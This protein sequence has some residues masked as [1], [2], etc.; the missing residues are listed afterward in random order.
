L[1]N[2]RRLVSLLVVVGA[3][4][5]DATPVRIA[6]ATDTVVINTTMLERLD[7]KVVN[8]N[9]VAIAGTRV[10][11]ASTAPDSILAIRGLNSIQCRNDGVARV[12]LSAGKLS[13]S[14]MVRCNII[15][16]IVAEQLVC[17]RLGNRPLSLSVAAYDRD[18][19][20]I[21]SPR[22]Y[23]ISDSSLVR[24][25]NGFMTPLRSGDGDIDYTNGRHRAVTL[26]RVLDTAAIADSG[27]L[28]R[29]L[30]VRDKMFESVCAALL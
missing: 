2:G 26:I 7:A 3:A 14:V 20:V 30:T 25:A 21:P 6:G 12:T 16:K 4:C 11:Y 8:R 15:E 1:T 18:G 17:T 9:G 27:R 19:N 28:S 10:A 5:T 13:S 29:T 24:I 23:I 22:L